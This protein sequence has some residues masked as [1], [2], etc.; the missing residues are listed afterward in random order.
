M[1]ARLSAAIGVGALG[2]ALVAGCGGGS[3][4]SNASSPSASRTSP[5]ATPSAISTPTPAVTTPTGSVLTTY[6]VGGS[7]CGLATTAGAVW[8]SDAEGAKLLRLDAD[9][10]AVLSTTALDP[11][12]CEITVAYGSLWVITQ[13][14]LLD[15][16]DPA[17][18]SVV[19]HIAV[20]ELSYQAIAT[21][22]AIWVSN[23]DGHS[24][25]RVDPATNQPTRALP[26]P[27]IDPG[28]MAYA[29]GSLW[30]GDDTSGATAL[31]RVDLR[32]Y[33]ATAVRAGRCPAYLT[34]LGGSVW[35]S[36]QEDGTVSRIDART[37]RVTAT[38]AAGSSPV[39]LNP[40]P[41]ARPEIWVP[42]D[43]GE[44]VTRIDATTARVIETI[45]AVGGPAVVRAIG[46]DVWVTLF[47]GGAVLRIHPAATDHR[48]IRI[49]R[50]RD[51]YVCSDRRVEGSGA[52]VEGLAGGVGDQRVVGVAVR[53]QRLEAVDGRLHRRDGPRHPGR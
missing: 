38:V 35:V 3:A 33:K 20:G 42:D 43:A 15:R 10:G 26:L 37:G 18:G 53:E 7:P 21:P 4:A 23:R 40:R 50:T 31:L 28:G 24:L 17:T 16:L 30:V 19:A 2:L 12:P 36:D 11:K 44:Q 39:N 45:P 46:G 13:S 29:G 5:S 48:C 6:A 49:G 9:S 27:G 51:R 1:T 8:V 34:T 52:G 41:G 22:G 25:T 47:A 14:G 32:T